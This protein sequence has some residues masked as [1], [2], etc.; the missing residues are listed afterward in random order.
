MKPI[1]IMER[2]DKEYYQE[3]VMIMKSPTDDQNE[4]RN[5]IQSITIELDREFGSG[6][7]F[8]FKERSNNFCITGFVD[9][10]TRQKAIAF[11]R[12]WFVAK[13]DNN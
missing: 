3:I 6:C 4:V 1:M 11:S 9:R 12:G 8:E 13:K 10:Q 2:L 5:D 7:F